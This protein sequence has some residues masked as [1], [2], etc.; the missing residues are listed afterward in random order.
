MSFLRSSSNFAFLVLYCSLRLISRDAK[1]NLCHL[2]MLLT[3]WLINLCYLV[4][5]A[6]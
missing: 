6:T 5:V 4:C 1:L 2:F 3:F